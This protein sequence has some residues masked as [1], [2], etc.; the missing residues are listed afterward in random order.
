MK[1]SNII[2]AAMVSASGLI[3]HESNAQIS[4]KPLTEIQKRKLDSA[5]KVYLKQ[6]ALEDK[7]KRDSL[8]L[9]NHRNPKYCPGCGMG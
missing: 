1:I 6:K 5:K 3:S 2:L 4:K 7:R 8:A 9:V